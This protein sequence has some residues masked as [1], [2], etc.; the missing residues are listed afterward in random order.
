MGRRLVALGC[1][2]PVMAQVHATT[3]QRSGCTV[4]NAGGTHEAL[5]IADD[6]T[7]LHGATIPGDAL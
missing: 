5:Y 6:G 3:S 1:L 4:S 7:V 2:T